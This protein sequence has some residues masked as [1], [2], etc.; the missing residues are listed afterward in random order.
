MAN[1]SLDHCYLSSDGSWRMRSWSRV[2]SKICEAAE[3]LSMAG[4]EEPIS[5]DLGETPA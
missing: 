5:I 3:A 4:Q 2:C 1:Q